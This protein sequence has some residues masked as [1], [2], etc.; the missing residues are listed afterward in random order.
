MLLIL[1]WHNQA[2]KCWANISLGTG[3]HGS[4]SGSDIF[5]PQQVK[6]KHTQTAAGSEAHFMVL[7][8]CYFWFCFGSLFHSFSPRQGQGH[9]WAIGATERHKIRE[10]RQMACET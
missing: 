6:L 1:D 10:I 7:Q 3:V 2:S 5:L 8:T 9:K 4:G